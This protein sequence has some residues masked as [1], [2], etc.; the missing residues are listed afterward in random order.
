MNTGPQIDR[1]GNHR[2]SNG[3]VSHRL[4]SHQPA[5]ASR[6]PF[7]GSTSMFGHIHEEIARQRHRE[8]CLE[9]RRLRLARALR[10]DRRAR[11]AVELAVRAG[12]RAGAEGSR[13]AVASH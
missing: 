6:R 5:P 10:A 7:T 3:A 8:A 11:R 13:A 2:D 12:E 1:D 4:N 9:A